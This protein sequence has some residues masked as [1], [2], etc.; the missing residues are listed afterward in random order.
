MLLTVRNGENYLGEAL[1]SVLAQTVPP[2]E[3]VV[4]D[5]GSTDGTLDLLAGFG[6]QVTVVRQP[7]T[8]TA[9][10]LNAALSRAQ[11]DLVAFLDHDDLWEPRALEERIDLI[12][13]GAELEITGGSTVQ[14]LSP[15]LDPATTPRFRFDS[16]AVQGALFGALVMRRR[17]FERV[18]GLDPNVIFAPQVDWVGR[19]RQ[20]GIRYGWTGTVVLRRRIHDTN[21]SVAHRSAKDVEVMAVLR[22]QLAR[23]RA[24]RSG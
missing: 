21:V 6:A 8:G 14:F 20:L 16:T 19:S 12:G 18:G 22:R 1:A 11:H 9:S 24:D 23:A 17:V 3:V 7:A 13:T 10:G 5:D 2:A 15:E 4:V